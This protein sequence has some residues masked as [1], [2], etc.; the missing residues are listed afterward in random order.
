MR[1]TRI[2]SGRFDAIRTGPALALSGR[3]HRNLRAIT[4]LFCAGFRRVVV[5]RLRTGFGVCRAGLP[6]NLL[7]DHIA[8]HNMVV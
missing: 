4:L 3:L 7:R 1:N 2:W 8:P 5:R 6:R